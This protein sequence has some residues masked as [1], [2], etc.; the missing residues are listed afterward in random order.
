MADET[1]TGDGRVAEPSDGRA[2]PGAGSESPDAPVAVTDAA[3]L[4]DLSE[5]HGTVLVDFYADWCG[6]CEAMEPVVERLAAETGAAV[7]T[8]DIEAAEEL[9]REHGVRSVPTFL[10]FED[11]EPVE[12][13]VGAQ[14][15][16]RLRAALE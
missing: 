14:D 7:A 8:A 12:R 1:R 6:P 10:V 3:D 9:A 13:F 15:A 4:D 5:R 16:D 11:G 2:G